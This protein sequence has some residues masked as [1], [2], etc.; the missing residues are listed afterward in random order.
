MSDPRFVPNSFQTPNA[1]IDVLMPLLTDSE[2]RVLMFMVRQILGW[3]NSQV[4]KQA[5]ISQSLIE[6]G[7]TYID[8]DG[9]EQVKAGCG[10]GRDAIRNALKSLVKYRI[11]KK[12]GKPTNDGQMWELCLLT[13]AKP[14][15]PGLTLRADTKSRNAQKQTKKAREMNPIFTEG[16]SST[17]IP[18]GGSSTAPQGGSSTS[19]QGGSSTAPN[20]THGNTQETHI[21]PDAE[22]TK[23]PQE[24]LGDAFGVQ[25]VTNSD[26][27]L[28]GK[29][30]K[31]LA[32]ANIEPSEYPDYIS[33]VKRLAKGTGD[34]KVTIPSLISGGRVSDYVA[35][36]Q[37][38]A[39]TTLK[40]PEQDLQAI[41]QEHIYKILTGKM[42][43]SA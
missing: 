11:V 33:W 16:G 15:I 5:R 6:N 43:E 7:Y 17:S 2:F 31:Q 18:E 35:T 41:G 37:S 22:T 8:K 3:Q 42:E 25:P 1:I 40:A 20:E 13:D 24:V 10:V 39:E 14:D 34:W 38:K 21:A 19:P 4:N 27:G 28:Y 26:W 29:V 23:K 30:C 32:E 36:K 9:I 12:I